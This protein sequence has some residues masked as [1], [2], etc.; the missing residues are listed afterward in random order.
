MLDAAPAGVTLGKA[1]AWCSVC[2][3]KHKAP[4]FLKNQLPGAFLDLSATTDQK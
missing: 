1:E 3:T 4:I 2:E